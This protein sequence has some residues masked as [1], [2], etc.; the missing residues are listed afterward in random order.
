[1][2]RS[3]A[4]SIPPSVSI[5]WTNIPIYLLAVSVILKIFYNIDIF[6]QCYN[7]SLLLMLQDKTFQ[8]SLMLAKKTGGDHLMLCTHRE[9][10]SLLVIGLVPMK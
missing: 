6:Y 4:L 8:M 10:A 2:R 1:M 7:F 3:S 5:P 9:G